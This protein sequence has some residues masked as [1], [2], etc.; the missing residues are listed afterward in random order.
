MS[1]KF[2]WLCV[3]YFIITP[4]GPNRHAKEAPS[5]CVEAFN[6]MPF[7]MQRRVKNSGTE[8]WFCKTVDGLAITNF[9][10][11]PVFRTESKDFLNSR[12]M[13]GCL[14]IKITYNVQLLMANVWAHF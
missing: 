10:I 8:G 4:S 7:D 1:G 9:R 11:F 6:A 14:S 13:K 2:W 12:N 5:P 3:Y